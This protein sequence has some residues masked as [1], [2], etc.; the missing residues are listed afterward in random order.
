MSVATVQSNNNTVQ[1]F[2]T[3]KSLSGCGRKPEMTPVLTRMVEATNQSNDHQQDHP[4]KSE[5]IWSRH[6]EADTS[7]TSFTQ[8]LTL[9]CH[10][11]MSFT[12]IRNL[13]V[14]SK[15]TIIQNLTEQC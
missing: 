2:H 1:E 4:D 14:K 10:L 8:C 12:A 15:F 13:L 5:Q 9:F 7:L 11:F 6:L 3:V